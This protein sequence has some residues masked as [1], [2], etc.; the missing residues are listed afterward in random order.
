MKCHVPLSHAH[1]MMQC[2]KELDNSCTDD[3]SDKISDQSSE[4]QETLNLCDDDH[5]DLMKI[6][7]NI[8]QDSN[9]PPRIM[10]LLLDQQR[11]LKE[12]KTGRRWSKEIIRLCLTMWCRSPRAYGDLRSSGFLLLP[13][14]RLLQIYKNKIHQ[15]AGINKE[16]LHWMKNEAVNKNIPPEGY[17]GGLMLD[18]MSIQSDLQFYSRDNK[19]YITGF[20]DLGDESAL[21]ESIKTKTS[22]MKLATHVLQ[23]VFLGF[24]GFRF[25]ICHFPT[26]QASA[27]DLYILTWEVINMLQV[28]GFTV[29]Y[30]S[31]DGAQT[32]RDFARIL[33][34]DFKSETVSTMKIPNI[35]CPTNPPIVFIMDYS[36]VVKKIRNNILKSTSSSNGKRR[37][38]VNG[39][40]ILWRHFY[41]AYLW[42]TSHNPL[43]VH[44]KL[45]IEHFELTSET[46]MRNK[47][48]EDVLGKEMLHLMQC[49]G[50]TLQNPSHLQSTIQL[51]Q[52]TSPLIDIFRDHRPIID[53]SDERL[54]T[55][56]KIL[57]WFKNWEEEVNSDDS[58]KQKDT[59]LIS[60]QTRSDI[61]SLIIGFRELCI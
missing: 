8:V 17:E 10:Q 21:V 14:H 36:H 42:D 24:S 35:Y 45:T 52:N 55:L 9:C 40:Y 49:Y 31:T 3:A 27:S 58:L 43:P 50:N 39:H 4:N 12:S 48:A 54:A 51:L 44:H 19:I 11:N 30:I 46:K 59:F 16:I 13:S 1:Q 47:L 5:D 60:H 22:N 23:Y 61:C 34:G 32:N 33:L 6:M 37:L 25:P 2:E 7:G 20:T 26:I 18:E 15:K 28:F 56:K 53:T 38:F 29:R 57:D 41:D